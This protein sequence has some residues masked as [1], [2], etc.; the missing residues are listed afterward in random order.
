MHSVQN[1]AGVFVRAMVHTQVRCERE[2]KRGKERKERK[3][4]RERQGDRVSSV[5]LVRAH[6]EST[7]GWLIARAAAI[8]RELRA[9]MCSF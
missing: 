4:E 9:F 7:S 6:V 1:G 2:R 5:S 8:C 3:K